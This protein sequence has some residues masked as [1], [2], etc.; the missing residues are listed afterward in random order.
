MST[1]D[2][3]NLDAFLLTVWPNADAG[4]FRLEKISHRRNAQH[5]RAHY[6]DAT[7]VVRV[8][9]RAESARRIVAALTALAGE[10]FAPALLA[11]EARDDGSF[12]V[13]MEDLGDVPPTPMDTQARLLEFVGRIRHLHGHE[14]FRSTVAQ[15]GRAEGEDSSLDWAE[16]EWNN[17]QALA[18]T[19]ER[20]LTA[21]RWLEKASAESKTPLERPLVVS[22]HGDLHNAN[23]RLTDRGPALIDWEEI[24]RWPLASELAD[25]VV[26]G[27]LDPVEVTRAYGAPGSYAP[28]VRRAAAAC[29]LSFYLYWLRTLLDG[30]DPRPESLAT[31]RAVCERLFE[32]S[33]P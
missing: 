3:P 33:S 31:V 7:V 26:F 22:G 15:F 10:S 8:T 25:F 5:W 12:V 29:A 9:D 17:L 14:R 6:D 11:S 23:W 21:R 30:S 2:D 19:D 4:A 24:R 1:F 20:V 16:A 32:D 13:A 28:T 27:E 18:P